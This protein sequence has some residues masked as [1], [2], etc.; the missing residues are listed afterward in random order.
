[1]TDPVPCRDMRLRSRLIPIVHNSRILIPIRGRIPI[2][3]NWG[4]ASNR[5][6]IRRVARAHIRRR[7]M[8]RQRI[9]VLVVVRRILG[10]ALPE[11]ALGRTGGV[12]VVGGGA[13]GL[14]LLAVADEAVFDEDGEEEENPVHQLA[15]VRFQ[16]TR[17]EEGKGGR[18]EK[19]YNPIIATANAAFCNLHAVFKLGNSVNPLLPSLSVFV[20]LVSPLPYGVVTTP[21][22]LSVAWRF[23]HAM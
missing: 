5:G 19:T 23:T 21:L 16:Q 7:R 22:Q 14:F 11:F 20:T 2:L 3:I 9:A 1:M 4:L 18:G 13:E 6:G 12:S 10:F 8:G 17:C 15:L